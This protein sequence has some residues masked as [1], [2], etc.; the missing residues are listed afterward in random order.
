MYCSTRVY[1]MKKFKHVESATRLYQ[2][3]I[4]RIVMRVPSAI[5]QQPIRMSVSVLD[6]KVSVYCL[7][8]VLSQ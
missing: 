8:F 2:N 3:T 4:L 6:R 5:G 1:S 7:T